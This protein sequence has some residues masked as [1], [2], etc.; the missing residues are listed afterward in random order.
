MKIIIVHEW[1]KWIKGKTTQKQFILFSSVLVGLSAGIVAVILKSVIHFILNYL[2]SL[3]FLNSK[4]LI[5]C[6]PIIGILLTVL[7]VQYFLKNKIEKGVTSLHRRIKKK[8]SNIPK[9]QMYDQ[10]IT[11]S[12]TVGFGV[13]QVLKHQYY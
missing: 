7:V 6:L 4:F 13:Q 2:G 10:V 5:A 8:S 3:K 11:S 9:E 12:L 1:I